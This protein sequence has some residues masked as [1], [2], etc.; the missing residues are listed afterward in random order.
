MNFN[1]ASSAF[2]PGRGDVP[3]PK[4]EGLFSYSP[5]IPSR[6][7]QTQHPKL[8]T[9]TLIPGS[10]IEYRSSRSF[11][12][13]GAAPKLAEA[14]LPRRSMRLALMTASVV[15]SLMSSP[16]RNFGVSVGRELGYRDQGSFHLRLSL[17]ASLR[18]EGLRS[19]WGLPVPDSCQRISTLQKPEIAST[20][21]SPTEFSASKDQKKPE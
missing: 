1:A 20:P 12:P 17:G 5:Q 11:K 7:P 6:K 4:L 19:F 15:I 14:P 16:L 10:D 3:I 9:Q 2:L 13:R 21:S 8:Q 18:F